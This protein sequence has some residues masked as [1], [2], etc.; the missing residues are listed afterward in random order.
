MPIENP[1]DHLIIVGPDM[2]VD[3][4]MSL[5]QREG[6]ADGAQLSD[7]VTL[8]HSG[9][10]ICLT[11]QGISKIQGECQRHSNSLLLIDTLS[12]SIKG[13]YEENQSEIAIPVMALRTAC[14][15]VTGTITT[16][17]NHHSRKDG[18]GSSGT[19]A[20][21]GSSALP[22]ACDSTISLN[23]FRQGID[24]VARTDCR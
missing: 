19:T 16:V 11:D 23:Y 9:T 4:W 2:H 18:Y 14:A 6:L 20:S 3:Q 13:M 7:K 1:F 24:G 10:Q 15:S 21:R 5:L 22:G 8:W 12:S 17:V